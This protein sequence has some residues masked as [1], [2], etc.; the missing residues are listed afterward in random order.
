MLEDQLT[1]P[2]AVFI[3]NKAS[4]SLKLLLSGRNSIAEYCT[5]AA[6]LLVGC[7]FILVIYIAQF[8]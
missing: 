1:F 5:Q 3:Y 4:Y 8:F 2:N 6:L 7:S